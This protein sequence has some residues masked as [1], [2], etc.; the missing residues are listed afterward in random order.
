MTGAQTITHP[1]IPPRRGGG[2]GTWW[3]KAWGRAVEESAFGV[4]E[5]RRGRAL[6]RAGEVGA[7]AVDPGSAVA[8]VTEGDDAWTVTIGVPTL[9]DRDRATF[10][11][12]VGAE[13]GRIAAMLAGQLPHALLEACEEA[14]IELLPY[15][16]ELGSTCTCDSWLDPCPHAL[17]VLTQV[18]WLLQADP[19]VLLQLRGL[20]RE[21][22]LAGLHA[23]AV[24]DPVADDLTV[25][26]DAALRAERIL[27]ALQAD[28]G[29]DLSR[30]W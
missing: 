21:E 8:A 3:S 27:A 24:T 17:A 4:A 2:A 9:D 16:A 28:P 18:G 15:G 14:G 22:L 7:I 5:L 13:S 6:A 11:E 30:W 25:A 20:S 1:R 19:F 12:L 23:L 10:V 29:A 26:E